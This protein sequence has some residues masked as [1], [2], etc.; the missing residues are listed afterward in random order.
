LANRGEFERDKLDEKPAAVIFTT[1]SA[2]SGFS[3]HMRYVLPAFPYFFVA[4]SQVA[5]SSSHVSVS[6]I[7]LL[8]TV[9]VMFFVM[10]IIASSMWIYP[11]SISYFN[12]T[13]G[14]PLKGGNHLLGSSL[15]WGQD[16]LYLQRWIRNRA[17]DGP[18]RL[19]YYGCVPPQLLNL[20][21]CQPIDDK[22]L[23]E[24]QIIDGALLSSGSQPAVF[25]LSINFINGSDSH[26]H[27]GAQGNSYTIDPALL[28]RLKKVETWERIGYTL[29][30]TATEPIPPEVRAR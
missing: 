22:S 4:L 2:K 14:G 20:H 10:W 9:F 12:E 28:S 18:L 1:V 3:E 25:V 7:A 21:Q 27:D 29:Q 6:R 23:A 5:I 15:D 26:A 17:S 30:A 16:L 8:R 11:H 19:A 24:L 13:V